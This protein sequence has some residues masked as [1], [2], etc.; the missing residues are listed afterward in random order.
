MNLDKKYTT[1]GFTPTSEQLAIQAAF[2]VHRVIKVNSCAGSGKSSTLR[3]LAENCRRNSLYL[4]FNQSVKQDAIGKF[5]SHVKC[6]TTHG[7]AGRFLNELQSK[8]GGSGELITAQTRSKL[9]CTRPSAV[10]DYFK[11]TPIFRNSVPI[12]TSSAIAT[13]VINTVS[14]FQ[15]S[16]DR[17]ITLRHVPQYEISKKLSAL[18]LDIAPLVER[19]L[20]LAKRLWTARTTPGNGVG[21]EFD[22][23]LKLWQLSNPKL[24]YDVIYLDE[25]QDSNECVLDV[26]RR[27]EH[28]KIV[29]VGDTYQSIYAFR[30]AT[31]AM[32]VITAP[33]CLLSQ[34]FRFGQ[35]IADLASKIISNKISITGANKPSAV[36]RVTAK[37]Y[38]M[39]FRTNQA[40]IEKA[41]SLVQQNKRIL[42][43]GNIANFKAML[44]SCTNL[45]K[46]NMKGV[47]HEDVKR[48]STWADFMTNAAEDPELLRIAKVVEGGKSKLYMDALEK[49]ATI[50]TEAKGP[51]PEYDIL[52]TTAHKSKG[53]EWDSVIIGDDFDLK[54]IMKREDEE[55]FDQQ[56]VNLF[57]VACTRAI[58]TLQLPSNYKFN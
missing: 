22:T 1:L 32:E 35:Q 20:A 2:D 28:C 8:A 42:C 50:S 6:L 48:Y 46:G 4:C 34:S 40:L 58:T 7:L 38:T 10:A 19:V 3:L 26:I 33:E 24:N 18:N 17:T 14:R 27:Q 55:G 39:L 54:T 53:K 44:S 12:V 52:L 41:I 9:K 29:Y 13:F 37:R 56:E 45:H 5:P 57:Y 21:F 31:N 23:Y 49:I 36:T 30:G 11:I 47:F 51:L 25:A 43:D 16:A 15:N